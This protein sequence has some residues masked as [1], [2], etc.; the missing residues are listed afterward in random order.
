MVLKCLVVVGF[1]GVAGLSSFP[2]VILQQNWK[3]GILCC[4]G[5]DNNLRITRRNS[6]GVELKA[7]CDA[8]AVVRSIPLHMD[9]PEQRVGAFNN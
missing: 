4:H 7:S 2:F 3:A 9:Y 1:G 6:S 5:L 8:D